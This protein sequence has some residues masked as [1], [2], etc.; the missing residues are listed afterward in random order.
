MEQR[1]RVLV[2]TIGAAQGVKG[3]VRIK[4]YTGEPTAI[5]RYGSLTS[6]DGGRCFDILSLRV[7]R[8][9]MVV[10][11]LKDIADRDAAA[12][13]TGIRLYAARNRLPPLDPDEVY[14]ADLIGALAVSQEAEPLG[15]VIGVENYGAGDLL[16]IDRGSGDTLL[17]P[18]TKAFVP[19]I[20]LAAGRLVIAQG[21]LGEAA[22]E[23]AAPE[24]G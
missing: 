5:G 18:F 1:Q 17:V 22:D 21:A 11:K 3:E 16:E 6:E 12:K 10:A 13:L 19:D 15:R 7:L 24:R 14:H 2:G 8:D 20:D 9:D 4:S 23:L